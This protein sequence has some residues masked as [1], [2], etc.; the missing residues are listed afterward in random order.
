MALLNPPSRVCGLG[1]EEGK[2]GSGEELGVGSRVKLR[3]RRFGDT[4]G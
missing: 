4:A 2:V 3:T 1:K